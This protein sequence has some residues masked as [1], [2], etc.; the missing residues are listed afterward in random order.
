[1]TQKIRYGIYSPLLY[2]GTSFTRAEKGAEMQMGFALPL[3]L[4]PVFKEL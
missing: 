2:Q 3:P 4:E 1:M